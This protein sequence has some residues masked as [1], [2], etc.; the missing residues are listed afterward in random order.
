MEII[1]MFSDMDDFCLM[2][3]AEFNKRLIKEGEKQ[4]NKASRL[5]ISEIMTIMVWFHQSGYRTFKDYYTK[6]V[7]KHLLWAFPKLVSYNRFVELQKSALIPLACYLET[8]F[9][10]C[11][12]ISFIDSTSIKV[13]HNRRIHS[14]KVFQD[15]AKRGK[16]SVDWFYGFK[17]HLVLN[18]QGQLLGIRLTTGNIDDREIVP[19][20]TEE[21]WGKLFGDKG[22]ISQRLFDLLFN[23]GLQLIT[24]VKSNMK[25][26]LLPFFDKLLL[27][28]RAIIESV[29]D[30]LK[31]ISQIEHSRHR[32]ISNF[33]FNLI[34]GLVSYTFRDKLPSIR[35]DFISLSLL[36]VTC[37]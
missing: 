11:T 5:S 12:G 20:I 4:R 17:L 33:L 3:E 30:Q 34:A 37:F 27:R 23:N 24:K 7:M 14:N 26:K 19:K 13:C 21:I 31:N 6:E 28:K 9:G 8:R 35:F 1:A 18:D 2:F 10:K 29:N 25:N 36:P 15:K 32:S 22:Y 16:T